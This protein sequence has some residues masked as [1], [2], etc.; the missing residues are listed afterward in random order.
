VRHAR[1][2]AAVAVLALAGCGGPLILQIHGGEKLN[3]NDKTPPENLPVDVRVFLLKDKTAFETASMEQL[4]TKEKYK[5][6][7]GSDLVGEVRQLTIM[8]QGAAEPPKKLDLGVIPP[9]V[10]YV[11]IMA[12]ISKKGDPPARR[13]VAVP[14]ELAASKIFELIE[15]RLEVK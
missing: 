6:V 2:A 11:G 13:H 3:Q 5:G 1:R 12:M 9:D 15:Y 4:W 8:A 10:K 14:K 7:L